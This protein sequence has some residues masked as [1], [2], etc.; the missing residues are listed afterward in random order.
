MDGDRLT[1]AGG[2]PA[3]TGMDTIMDTGILTLRGIGTD[4]ML[5]GVP[6]TGNPL[7]MPTDRD[8]PTMFITT[9]RRGLEVPGTITMTHALDT[10]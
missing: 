8:P 5:A 2:D 3:D 9:V 7:R 6:L 4:T 1:E 10:E